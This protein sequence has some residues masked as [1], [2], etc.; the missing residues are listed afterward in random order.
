MKAA[1]IERIKDIAFEIPNH[2][3]KC[4]SLDQIVNLIES[5]DPGP[6]EP[7]TFDELDDI[8]NFFSYLN[9]VP[10]IIC[11]KSNLDK[12]NNLY[13]RVLEC[14]MAIRIHDESA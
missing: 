4:I 9:E 13:D 2:N 3:H 7:L 8:L 11:K 10:A 5:Y 12:F 6:I 14:Q 1:L